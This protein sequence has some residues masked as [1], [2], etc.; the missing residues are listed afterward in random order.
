MSPKFS[1]AVLAVSAEGSSSGG[2]SSLEQNLLNQLADMEEEKGLANSLALIDDEDNSNSAGEAEGDHYLTLIPDPPA[3]GNDDGGNG[4][5]RGR[6]QTN[7][8]LMCATSNSTSESRLSTCSNHKLK[9]AIF[10]P[11]TMT[12]NPF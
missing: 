1:K 5:F 9:K 7:T 11:F 2:M 8:A 6:A 12:Q 3:S 4:V 10:S